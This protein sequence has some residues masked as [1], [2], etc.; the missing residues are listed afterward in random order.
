[1]DSSL[2]DLRNKLIDE[3]KDYYL[4]TSHNRGYLFNHQATIAELIVDL[5]NRSGLDYQCF[6]IVIGIKSL[7]DLDLNLRLNEAFNGN[8]IHYRFDHVRIKDHLPKLVKLL[9]VLDNF[10]ESTIPYNLISCFTVKLYNSVQ[11]YNKSN[12]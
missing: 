9:N 12:M 1:M 3:T 5:F 4:I 2:V 10:K 7:F 11:T 8:I 6:D